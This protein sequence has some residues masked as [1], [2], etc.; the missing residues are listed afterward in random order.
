MPTINRERLVKELLQ[1]R[2][3]YAPHKPRDEEICALLRED[4]RGGDNYKIT[5]QGLGEAGISAPK[6]KHCTGEE[7]I[8]V[9]DKYLALLLPERKKLIKAGIV[10]VVE[11]WKDAYGGQVRVKLF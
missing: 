5:I 10:K 3:S 2:Q 8:L 1:M 9:V 11:L 4:A 7:P 6:D